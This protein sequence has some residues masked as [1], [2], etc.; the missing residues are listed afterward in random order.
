SRRGG[1]IL[2]PAPGHLR[3][4]DCLATV[5][6]LAMRL[7]RSGVTGL[8]RL[9]DGAGAASWC[10]WAEKW[11]FDLNEVLAARD[12][13]GNHRYGVDLEWPCRDRLWRWSLYPAL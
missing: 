5:E 8:G 4:N 2:W 12:E 3:D 10:T 7:P 6:L 1:V 11:P 9:V 13:T